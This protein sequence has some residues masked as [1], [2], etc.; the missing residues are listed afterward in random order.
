MR[1]LHALGDWEKLS[2]LSQEKWANA[3]EEEKKSIAP[4]GA[5]AAWGLFQWE[6]MDDYLAVLKEDS[7]DGAFFRFLFFFFFFFPPSFHFFLYCLIKIKKT[8]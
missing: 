7:P 2:Q 4:L 3:G 6:L 8:F 5:A 1:C